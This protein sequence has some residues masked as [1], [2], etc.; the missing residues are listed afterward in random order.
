MAVPNPFSITYAGQEVGGSTEYQLH[1]PYVIEK[2]HDAFRLVFDVVIVSKSYVELQSKSDTIEAAFSKR[3]VPTDTIEINLDGSIWTYTHGTTLLN[4]AAKIL[5]SANDETD[6]GF[7]RAYTISIEAELPASADDGLRDVEVLVEHEA[8]R[9]KVV[10]MRGTYTATTVEHA[11]DRYQADFDDEALAFLTAIDDTATFELVG[12]EFTYDRQMTDDATPVPNPHTCSFTRQYVQLLVNQSTVL[13]DDTEIRDHR[14]VFTDLSQHPGDGREKVTRLRRVVGS[15]DCAIDIDETTD[16]QTVYTNKVKPWVLQLFRSNFTPQV[17]GLE[18]ERVSYDET[19]KRMSVSLQFLYQAANSEA[20]VEVA[21]SVAYRETRTLDFTPTHE[22]DEF[23]SYVDVGW[24]TLERTWNRTVIAIG[25]D[26]PR[27][28]IAN[29]PKGG[30]VGLWDDEVAG[31]PGPDRRSRK[32]SRAGWNI[33][34][35]VSQAEPRRIGDPNS[36]QQIE[37]IVLT[38]TVVE[39]FNREPGARTAVPIRTNPTTPRK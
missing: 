39:R 6:K 9:R 38:E 22:P 15:F 25:R 32:I 5:K 34:N 28:R 1:G 14:V 27:L 13:L 24:A 35:N 10:T 21:Q 31:I 33:V 11:V 20:I 23:A 29:N 2:A 3:M 19:A 12:E 18:E 7:S 17:F 37:A 30:V 26:Q 16:L 4:G 36:D 8:S